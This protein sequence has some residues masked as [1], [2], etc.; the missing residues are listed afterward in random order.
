MSLGF[1]FGWI[2][3]RD[4]GRVRAIRRGVRRCAPCCRPGWRLSAH[5]GRVRMAE[6]TVASR[7]DLGPAC[8]VDGRS[9]AAT[10]ALGSPRIRAFG[11]AE[12]ITTAF[13]GL[14]T[15]QPRAIAYAKRQPAPLKPRACSRV[16]GTLWE[17][18][19]R[20]P[21]G[22]APSVSGRRPMAPASPWGSESRCLRYSQGDA[23]DE[24]RARQVGRRGGLSSASFACQTRCMK[25]FVLIPGAG[26]DSLVY[27]ATIEALSVLVT[28]LWRHPYP[29]EMSTRDRAITQT[30]SCGR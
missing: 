12:A 4:D 23:L 8:L 24:E 9:P 20:S 26:T 14:E 1:V 11:T 29:C 18:S 5:H 6:R 16:L 13:V 27:A 2:S 30:P 10:Q 3:D 17:R 22:R 28:G 7:S 19:G 25:T 21:N 15:G